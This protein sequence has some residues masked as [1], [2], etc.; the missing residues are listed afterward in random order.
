[1]KDRRTTLRAVGVMSQAEA[2]AAAR[3][4]DDAQRLNAHRDRVMEA[5]AKFPEGE[6]KRN[7]Q[8]AT[9]PDSAVRNSIRSSMKYSKTGSSK[10]AKSK[11][12]TGN[13]TT[14]FASVGFTGIQWDKQCRP[15]HRAQWDN[16]PDR[17]VSLSHCV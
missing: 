5:F 11:K 10:A 9:D 6:T 1:M 16:P 3:S 17:G 13:F 14:P 15:S 4:N 12:E 7:E 2:K 8:S